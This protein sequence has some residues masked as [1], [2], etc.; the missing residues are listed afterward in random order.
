[1]TGNVVAPDTEGAEAA[2]EEAGAIIAAG[3][4]AVVVRSTTRSRTSMSP[5]S[6]G[7]LL[8][9]RLGIE[10]V[11]TTQTFD[12]SLLGLQADLLGAHAF[13]LRTVIC[14]TGTPPPRGDYPELR[15]VFDADALDLI[16]ALRDLNGAGVPS[17]EPKRP[18]S[19]LVGARVNPAAADL[20]WEVA[21]TKQKLEAGIDFLVTDPIFAIEHLERFLDAVG[22]DVVP[23]LLGVLALRD[24]EHAEFLHFESAGVTIP[25][26]VL[27]RLRDAD[28]D[29]AE[30]GRAIAGELVAAAQPLV[31]GVVVAPVW[32][33]HGSSRTLIEKLARTYTGRDTPDVTSESH[34]L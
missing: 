20:D 1:V 8:Q 33:D 14:T 31:R 7:L 6:F 18:T 24:F 2:V 13:G 25:D 9:N 34:L 4:D 19:F 12:K 10:A 23:L 17:R 21:R 28:G 26:T 32:R 11:L 27:E 29:P 30:V 15:R 5:I 3:A 22:A 16:A